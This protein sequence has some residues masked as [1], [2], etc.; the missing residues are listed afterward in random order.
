MANKWPKLSET[1]PKAETLLCCQNCGGANDV[2]WR[3]HDDLDKPTHLAIV[4]C[5]KCSDMI[6]PHPRLYSRMERLEPLP[7]SM[8]GTCENCVHRDGAKC[9]HWALTANG[10]PGLKLTFP[11]PTT[12]FVDG[13][14]KNR[15]WGSR[16][17]QYHEWPECIGFEAKA[18]TEAV[19]P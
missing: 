8:S 18:A 19:K 10:G 16:V 7:G 11:T 5:N 12:I 9:N 15:R 1:L 14:S 17:Q 4:L 13:F 3:E 6:E 2:R